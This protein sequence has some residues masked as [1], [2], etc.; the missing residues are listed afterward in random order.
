VGAET[1]DPFDAVCHGA[2]C[3]VV[4]V[5]GMPIFSDDSHF[6]ASYVRDQVRFFDP[7]LLSP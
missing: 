3:Q 6:T 1:R 7:L 2:Q 4:T 5:E